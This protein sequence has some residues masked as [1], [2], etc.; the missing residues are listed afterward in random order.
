MNRVWVALRTLER[1]LNPAKPV[2]ASARIETATYAVINITGMALEAFIGRGVHDIPDWPLIYSAAVGL[3][4]LILASRVQKEDQRPTLSMLFLMN[5]VA[6]STALYIRNPYYAGSFEHWVPFEANKLG[7]LIAALMAPEFWIGSLAIAAHALTSVIQYELFPDLVKARIAFAEPWA[8]LA[9]ALVGALILV[10][11]FQRIYAENEYR[12][13]QAETAAT[14]RLIQTM[15]RLKSLMNTP[16]QSIRL[17]T[18]IQR[19][20][21]Q[22]DDVALSGLESAV[23]DLNELNSMLDDI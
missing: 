23:E 6:M 13:I 14:Q 2:L 4:V 21:E 19:E 3:F 18:A 15:V 7:C 1:K 10:S 22:R 11:K 9:F 20:Q 12:R 16:I 5:A 8:T 17:S